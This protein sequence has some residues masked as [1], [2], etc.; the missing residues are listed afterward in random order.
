[1]QY[2]AGYSGSRTINWR[3]KDLRK[4]LRLPRRWIR[5]L[6]DHDPALEEIAAFK[7]LT[8]AEKKKV[9]WEEVEAISNLVLGYARDIERYTSV[10][11][12][13]Q[14]KNR[15]NG[16]YNFTYDWLDYIRCCRKLGMDTERKDVLFPKDF[17]RAHDEAVNAVK[18]QTDE[19]RELAFRKMVPDISISIN[20]LSITTARSQEELNE[21]SRALNHCVRTYGE[22]IL[23]GES[24][25]FFIRNNND[26]GTPYYTLETDQKGKFIQCRGKNNC[27]MTEEV[28]E[29]VEQFKKDI[30]KILKKVKER[31]AA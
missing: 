17:K 7:S 13:V 22:K 16:S 20:E 26:L 2:V 14:Y 19:E 28:K 15:Q 12:F 9:T 10:L 30:P 6:Q 24:L 1:M 23:R 18:V 4:I 29:V 31:S 5:F 3:G 11:K 25:I 27:S 21:E 8:E